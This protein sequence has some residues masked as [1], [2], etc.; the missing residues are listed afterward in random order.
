MCLP[1]CVRRWGPVLPNHTTLTREGARWQ[2]LLPTGAYRSLGSAIGE[3]MITTSSAKVT[4]LRGLWMCF[5]EGG[6]ACQRKLVWWLVFRTS[7][8]D[9][10]SFSNFLSCDKSKRARL[11]IVCRDMSISY[12]FFVLHRL[13]L[14]RHLSVLHPMR[15]ILDHPRIWETSSFLSPVAYL[16][17]FAKQGGKQELVDH[18]T[19]SQYLSSLRRTTCHIFILEV[20]FITQI[21]NTV[22][23]ALGSYIKVNEQIQNAR[24]AP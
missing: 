2:R 7:Q 3:H 17:S 16:V 22:E 20:R 23:K 5:V 13:C 9:D 15:D 1:R 6:C 19:M 11:K 24:H 18:H 12:N 21:C 4:H 8:S 10:V 14:C